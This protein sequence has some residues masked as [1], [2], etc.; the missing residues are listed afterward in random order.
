MKSP[1][2]FLVFALALVALLASAACSDG[3]SSLSSS[4]GNV[5]VLLTADASALAAAVADTGTSASPQSSG[6][7]A[8]TAGALDHGDGSGDGEDVL[9]RLE[10]AN[11]TFASL[12]ARNLDG[13]LISL[14]VDLPRTVDLIG[15]AQGG[16]VELPI[17]TLPPGMYDQMVVVITQLELVFRNGARVA[18]TPPGGGWTSIIRV[19]PFEV[20]EGEVVTIELQFQ[21]RQAFRLLNNVFSFVPNFDCKH[22]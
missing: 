17:G 10:Q 12:L 14:A 11:A 15:L 2:R 6:P 5:R 1:R 21:P 18:V 9:P 3:N 7:T 16:T 20:I 22:D 8:P 4:N 13:E 19:T